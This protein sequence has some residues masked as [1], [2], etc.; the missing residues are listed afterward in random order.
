[1]IT[2]HWSCGHYTLAAIKRDITGKQAPREFKIDEAVLTEHSDYFNTGSNAPKKPLDTEKED[3]SHLSTENMLSNIDDDLSYDDSE[4]DEMTKS[5][6]ILPVSGKIGFYADECYISVTEF[7]KGLQRYDQD[8]EII[9]T[10]IDD[11]NI[12]QVYTNK[13]ISALENIGLKK[14]Q[15]ERQFSYY[16]LNVIKQ[17]PTPTDPLFAISVF[18]NNTIQSIGISDFFSANQI[19]Q[20]KQQAENKREEQKY[21]YPNNVGILQN[22]QEMNQYLTSRAK[23]TYGFW[24]SLTGAYSGNDYYQ[25]RNSWT[26]ILEKFTAHCSNSETVSKESL[27]E[28]IENEVN[29]FKPGLFGI[30]VNKFKPG[31]FGFLHRNNYH[32]CLNNL[33]NNLNQ[34]NHDLT[35]L[36]ERVS[37]YYQIYDH[38]DKYRRLTQ[39][40][41]HHFSVFSPKENDPSSITREKYRTLYEAQLSMLK[42]EDKNDF[43]PVK[44]A[45]KAEYRNTA[46]HARY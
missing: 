39:S 38:M 41:V 31:F 25:R 42:E 18:V 8:L 3:I 9:P 14:I 29:K 1:M 34:S 20:F 40:Y 6:G 46:Y 33:L 22:V 5:M 2:D 28:L 32:T 7:E 23:E 35:E 37:S 16:E 43:L 44:K 24:G 10:Q 21:K 26:K 15:D 17:L 12:L 45:H 11:Q 19:T 13:N 36:Q 27:I 30:L 4:S